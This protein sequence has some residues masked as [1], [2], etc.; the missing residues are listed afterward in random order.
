MPRVS[1]RGRPRAAAG[2]PPVAGTRQQIL[3]A[4]ADALDAGDATFSLGTIAGRA[5]LT[6]QAVYLHFRDRGDLLSAA[7]EELNRRLDLEARRRRFV[8]ATDPDDALAA[9]VAALVEHGARTLPAL[10]AVRRLLED[11]AA[12]RAAWGR[13]PR[14]RAADVRDVIGRL[15]AAGRLRAE[16]AEADAVALVLAIVSTDAIA[17]LVER[18]RWPPSRAAAELLRAVRGSILAP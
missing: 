1:S 12:A 6:R 16:L 7:V 10:R 11:D 14:G 3:T 13:R 8:D 9:L 17:Q 5:G 15:A 4:A 2:R 18:R